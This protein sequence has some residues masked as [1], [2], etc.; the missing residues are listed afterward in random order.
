MSDGNLAAFVEDVCGESHLRV[1]ADLG[2]GFVRLRSS[3]AERRQAAQDIRCSEDIIIEML[4]NARDANA[5]NIYVATTREGSQRRIV[6]I[7]DGNGV[8]EHMRQL[9]FEPRVT[10]KLDS[11]HMDKWGVH[12]R[13]M[14]LYS[15]A[16]NA[17]SASIVASVEQGGSAFVVET[18]LDKLP[19][20][21]DQSTF[22]A[23]DAT[24]GG[25]ISVRGPKNILRTASE[26][27]IES[28][29]TCQVYLGSATDIAATLYAQGLSGVTAEMRSRAENK[30]SLPVC[31][32]L[33]A[34]AN[35]AHFAACAANLGLIMSERS[36]RRIMDG[37]IAPVPS[38]LARVSAAL[39]QNG[40][41]LKAADENNAPSLHRKDNRGLK[42][43]AEDLQSF[44]NAI[45][46]AFATLARDYY[47]QDN[48]EPS[49]RVSKDAIRITI[50]AVKQR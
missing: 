13:G 26:F 27:A 42:I 40:N 39:S 28:R 46:Q 4:R 23:F 21:T 38:M 8:P 1:E 34:T 50:P 10:S 25:T 20:K 17:T 43:A 18:D 44:S 9:I 48:V 30:S 36:A 37:E 16:V 22:P 35:P 15:I 47:L 41:I 31:Q 14:A 6:M 24:E 45:Q 2:G 33:A 29:S 3:E 5:S 7:D 32:R 19:E 11:M 12:G 49:I